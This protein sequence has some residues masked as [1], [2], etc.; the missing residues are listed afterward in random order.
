MT[1]ALIVMEA[2]ELDDLKTSGASELC[3]I[4]RN[5]INLWFQRK[6]ETGNVKAK[7]KPALRQNQKITD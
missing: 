4:S 3:N 5:T 2:I 7:Q 6:A 1:S